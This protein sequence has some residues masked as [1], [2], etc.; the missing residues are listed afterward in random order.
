MRSHMHMMSLVFGSGSVVGV[1]YGGLGV[2]KGLW[3]RG[4]C[5]WGCLSEPARE[6]RIFVALSQQIDEVFSE[7]DW[8]FKEG[9]AIGD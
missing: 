2:S 4:E 1:A 9:R 5:W 8:G 7:M 3:A 6:G